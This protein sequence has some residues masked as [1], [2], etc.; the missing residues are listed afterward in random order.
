MLYL[1]DF[2][3]DELQYKEL[4]VSWKVSNFL[5]LLYSIIEPGCFWLRAVMFMGVVSM[6]CMKDATN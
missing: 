1:G 5:I 2:L 6:N 3:P 4:N